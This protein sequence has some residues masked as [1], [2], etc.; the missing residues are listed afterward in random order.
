MSDLKK[1][2]D[3]ELLAELKR[4]NER[5]PGDPRYESP[6]GL[7][8]LTTEGDVEGRS[9]TTIVTEYGH[10]G[11]LLVKYADAAYYTIS[12][13]LVSSDPPPQ[14]KDAGCRIFADR[15]IVPATTGGRV[16]QSEMDAL[17]KFLGPKFDVLYGEYFRSV[18]IK[19]KQ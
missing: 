7:W 12:V 10:V 8:R 17:K 15:L 4:R 5:K 3:V 14:K 6:V 1:F 2:S 13:D 19:R 16:S 18:V 9:T 11:D